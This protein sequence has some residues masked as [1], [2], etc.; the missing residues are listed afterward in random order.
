MVNFIKT[1]VIT[2]CLFLMVGCNTLQ[3]EPVVQIVEVKVPVNQCPANHQ[4]IQKPIRPKL[5]IDGIT[6][7][8]INDPGKVVKSYKITVKQLQGYVQSLE[9]GFEAYRTICDTV[10]GENNE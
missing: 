10:D 6:E 9:K 5:A 3:T 7:E 1:V 4:S 2:T 8:D